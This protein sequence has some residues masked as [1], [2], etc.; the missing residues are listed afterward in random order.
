[1]TPSIHIRVLVLFQGKVYP[2]NIHVGIF[3]LH[4][5][6]SFSYF[7]LPCSFA[8]VTKWKR[9]RDTLS[10]I[11]NSFLI[12]VC[13]FSWPA[14]QNIIDKR[15]K[16]EAYEENTQTNKQ[17]KKIECWVNK[18]LG[19]EDNKREHNIFF[20]QKERKNKQIRRGWIRKKKEQNRIQ[21]VKWKKERN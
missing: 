2:T 4:L 9:P 16:D 8:R 15:T 6:I 1:M 10:K 21:N 14:S 18:S 20:N 5:P 11:I 3:P 17:K 13:D 12:V 19:T 7:F